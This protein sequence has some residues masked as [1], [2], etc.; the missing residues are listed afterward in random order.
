MLTLQIYLNRITT[1]HN[2]ATLDYRGQFSNSRLIVADFTQ[3][4]NDIQAALKSAAEKNIYY[5]TEQIIRQ[6][7]RHAHLFGRARTVGRWLVA[8]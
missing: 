3:F 2:G 5:A 4:V 8:S 6:S 1:Q 7:P